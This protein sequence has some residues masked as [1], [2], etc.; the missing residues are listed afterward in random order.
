M[1]MRTSCRLSG[2][3]SAPPLPCPV[4]MPRP[5]LLRRVCGRVRGTVAYCLRRQRAGLL[6]RS[7]ISNNLTFHQDGQNRIP[8][9]RALDKITKF[10]PIAG[11]QLTRCELSVPR[12][13][14]YS[15]HFLYKNT[16]T[17]ILIYAYAYRERGL[18]HTKAVATASPYSYRGQ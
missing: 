4:L 15:V 2:A 5:D 1:V 11:Y 17:R 9:R 13:E 3:R 18:L 8:A 14:E 12:R 7:D 6:A 10:S 16:G